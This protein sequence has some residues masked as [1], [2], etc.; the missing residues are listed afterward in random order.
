[1]EGM[2]L[3]CGGRE[4]VNRWGKNGI[5]Y[6]NARVGVPAEKSEQKEVFH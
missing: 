3:G 5:R 4:C 1:M 2:V 6:Q